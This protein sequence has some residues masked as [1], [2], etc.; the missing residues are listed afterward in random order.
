MENEWKQSFPKTQWLQPTIELIRGLGLI[1]LRNKPRWT[2]EAYVETIAEAMW[3]IWTIRNNRTFNK[4]EIP[5]RMAI[6]MLKEILRTKKEIEWTYITKIKGLSH[7]DEKTIEL[8][9]NWGKE[10]ERTNDQSP[11]DHNK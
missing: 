5:E 11:N 4:K 3:L 9:K 10:I 7:R 2:N 6:K 1:H 8:E